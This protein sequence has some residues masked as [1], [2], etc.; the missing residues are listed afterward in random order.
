MTDSEIRRNKNGWPPVKRR[1]ELAH[2]EL[3][4]S[5]CRVTWYSWIL[6]LLGIG[7]MKPLAKTWN[8]D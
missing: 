6:R 8:R 5:E 4:C 2:H 7:G 1:I 3:K